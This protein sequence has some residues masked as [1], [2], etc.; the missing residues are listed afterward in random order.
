MK[1]LHLEDN[2][3]D[4]ELVRE[5]L[6]EEWPDCRITVVAG[7]EEYVAALAA[8]NHDLIISDFTLVRFDGTSALKLAHEHAPGIPFI[9]LSGTIGAERPTDTSHPPPPPHH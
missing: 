7:E 5:I 6:A 2:A 4:A 9:F 8:G 1:I 3:H